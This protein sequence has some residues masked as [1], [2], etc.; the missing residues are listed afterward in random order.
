MKRI[1]YPLHAGSSKAVAPKF[2]TT[3]AFLSVA[4]ILLIVTGAA[5]STSPK[6]GGVLHV[7]M[8]GRIATI[9][10]R[11]WPADSLRAAATERIAALIFDRLVRFDDHGMPQAALA[12]SWQ[13]DVQSKRWQFRLR[14]GTKF[15]D[16]SP[17]SPEVAA[18]ALQQ[19]LGNSFD[20]SA[21]SDSVLIQA[22]QSLPEF[23]AQL[24]GGRYFIFHSSSDGT[25]S[26]T[27]PFRV[28]QWPAGDALAKVVLATNESCWAGRPFV[29]GIE[30]SMGVVRSNRPMQSR[31][32][33]PI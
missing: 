24:A 33:K 17:L 29:D 1:A 30:I 7:Q 26:G 11:Q 28:T 22:D 32:A 20:V 31:S 10:P 6:F 23:A 27:G 21:T 8:S 2:L 3:R 9:D 16:G 25:L 4:A 15:A 19:L 5:A 14:E 18:I 13:H 12:V